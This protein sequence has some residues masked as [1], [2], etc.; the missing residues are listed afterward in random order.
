MRLTWVL[1]ISN[2]KK[3]QLNVTVPTRENKKC[4][5]FG[6]RM[7]SSKMPLI[8]AGDCSHVR[9]RRA[10]S[11]DLRLNMATEMGFKRSSPSSIVRAMG[12]HETLSASFAHVFSKIRLVSVAGPTLLTGETSRCPWINENAFI[13]FKSTGHDEGAM[14]KSVIDTSAF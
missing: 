1:L 8:V 2:I 13:S 4:S 11:Y 12:T 3:K 6:F 9:T 14:S 7:H 10:L 5:S